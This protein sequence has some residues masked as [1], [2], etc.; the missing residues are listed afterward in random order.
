MLDLFNSAHCGGSKPNQPT[1]EPNA[2]ASNTDEGGRSITGNCDEYPGIPPNFLCMLLDPETCRQVTPIFMDAIVDLFAKYVFCLNRRFLRRSMETDFLVLRD[3][4]SH[5]F[6]DDLLAMALAV[7][8]IFFSHRK[9]LAVQREG[10]ADLDTRN[11]QQ[12]RGLTPNASGEFLHP[13]DTVGCD[14]ICHCVNYGQGRL[15]GLLA[16]CI[17]LACTDE[18]YNEKCLTIFAEIMGYL[19][20]F[21]ITHPQALLPQRR[22]LP[23]VKYTSENVISVLLE[24]PVQAMMPAYLK[25]EESIIDLLGHGSIICKDPSALHAMLFLVSH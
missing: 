6:A 15:L 19:V 9:E 24:Q 2:E 21:A 3:E 7:R 18:I 1:H 25:C 5:R 13:E 14:F 8:T 22:G 4:K 23:P 16:L 17:R 11:T 20:D 12:P 10:T